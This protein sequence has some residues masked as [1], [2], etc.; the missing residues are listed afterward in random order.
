MWGLSN[1]FRPKLSTTKF[2]RFCAEGASTVNHKVEQC[3]MEVFVADDLGLLG[4]GS[5]DLM[6]ELCPLQD[7]A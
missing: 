1:A 2:R 6:T 4:P 7:T 3:Q 5:P